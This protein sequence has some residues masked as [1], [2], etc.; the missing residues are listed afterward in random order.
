MKYLALLRGINVGGNCKVEMPRLKQV[1]ESSGFSNVLTYINSGN[2]IF[3]APAR[4]KDKLARAIE[5]TLKKSFGFEIKTLV[6]TA[7]E[8]QKLSKGIPAT[9]T[10]D[11]EQKTDV[12]FLWDAFDS[13]STIGEITTNS[14]IDSLKYISGAIAWNVHR[15]NYNKSGMRKFI[16]TK[17]YK[18][19]TAR[20]VNTV[21]KLASLMRID[22]LSE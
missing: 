14:D 1:F 12:L 3:E 7:S 5:K 9:W 6:R 11:A 22:S 20:N 18:H 16:G 21:R 15:K 17:V 10:N 8:I 4:P 19:M 2:I 13:K